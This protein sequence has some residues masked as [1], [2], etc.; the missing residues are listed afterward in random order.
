MNLGL[1]DESS[2]KK[3]GMDQI[4]DQQNQAQATRQNQDILLLSQQTENALFMKPN[5]S[6]KVFAGLKSAGI[7]L[8]CVACA[9]LA[10]GLLPLTLIGGG[11]FALGDSKRRKYESDQ[12][13][14]SP[15]KQDQSVFPQNSRLFL[16]IAI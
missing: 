16:T 11:I 5:W 7:V 6:E 1:P 3:C 14:A 10:I 4:D 9:A 13:K 2:I 15:G 8:G 12:D